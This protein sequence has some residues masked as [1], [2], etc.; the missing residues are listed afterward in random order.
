M[1][2][3]ARSDPPSAVGRIREHATDH[4]DDQVAVTSR[5]DP[6][7][8]ADVA[9]ELPPACAVRYPS[10]SAHRICQQKPSAS[11]ATVAASSSSGI[12]SR[13]RTSTTSSSGSPGEGRSRRTIRLAR[14]VSGLRTSD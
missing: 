13:R 2:Q 10:K 9:D 3:Q 5:H 7:Q 14:R 8:D 11:H 1:R 12:D 4:R 6:T